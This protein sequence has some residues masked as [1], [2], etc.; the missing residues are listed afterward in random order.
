MSPKL[1]RQQIEKNLEEVKSNKNQFWFRWK[2][3]NEFIENGKKI[4]LDNETD[5]DLRKKTGEFIKL[6]LETL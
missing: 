5:L 2:T 6:Y 1:A 4:K 3:P